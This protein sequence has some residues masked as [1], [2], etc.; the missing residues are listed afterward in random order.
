MITPLQDK[1]TLS[2]DLVVR[3]YETKTK[4]YIFSSFSE[5]LAHKGEANY[6][7]GKERDIGVP[8]GLSYSP[9]LAILV[10]TDTIRR[11]E[12]SSSTNHAIVYADDGIIFTDNL[13]G[14]KSFA[15]LSSEN[16]LKISLKKSRLL[17][18][19]NQ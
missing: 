4:D 7:Y 14:V 9:L 16:H 12:L 15:E 6:I 11:W 3:D 17:K 10:L 8:M 1:P 2:L 18:D 5:M 19:N 13:S